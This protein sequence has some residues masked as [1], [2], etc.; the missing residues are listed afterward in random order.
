MP[1]FILDKQLKSGQREG[2][3]VPSKGL[4]VAVE[5]VAVAED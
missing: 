5:L 1:F 3:M 4:Q 2:G